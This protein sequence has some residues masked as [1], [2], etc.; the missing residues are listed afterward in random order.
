M[1]RNTRS[2]RARIFF[3][4]A[5]L[6]VLLSIF[7]LRLVEIQVVRADELNAAALDTRSSST[8]IIGARGDIV[9]AN[10]TVLAGSVQRFDIS[11][12]PKQAV[13]ASQAGLKESDADFAVKSRAV[14][15]ADTEKLGAALGKSGAEILGVIDAA[16]AENPKSDHAYIAKSV[17]TEVW[18]AV[19]DLDIPW[20]YAQSLP[21]RSYPNGAVAG[22][23]VGFVGA[24][25]E[26]QAGLELGQ[27]SCLAGIDGKEAYETGAD[28]VRLPDTTRTISEAKPGGTLQLTIDSDLQW[29]S[30]QALAEQAQATGA[31]WGSLVV[32][33]AKTGKLLTV[34]DYPSVDPNNVDGTAAE[35]RGSRAFAAS[36]EPGSTFKALTSA[37]VIDS[38]QADPYSQVVAPY[39]MIF[40]NGADVNDSSFHGDDHLTLTGVLIDSSNTGM[41]QF[42]ERISDD[43]RYEYMKKFGLGKE[44]EVHFPSEDSGDLNGDGPSTWDN[45]TRYATMFGQGMTSTAIQNASVYQAIA[46]NGVRLP[47][48]LTTGCTKADGTVVDQ[49][50]TEGVQVVSPGAARAT[51]D[52]LEMVYKKGWLASQ[53]NVPGYRVA[54]KTGTAQM[55][56]GTGKYSKDYIVSITGYA[57]ADDPQYVV[58]VSLARPVNMN[59]SAAPA[60]VFQ[61]VMSQV[62]KKYRVVPSGAPAPELPANW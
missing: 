46:N 17:D 24:D 26:A 56:D 34:A 51:S 16:L 45:Q 11:I 12:S 2:H 44:T 52:M 14:L 53:W 38:G 49:P 43:S 22:N 5:M 48:Q 59:T 40:P 18:R 32:M 60:P 47:V 9:D 57:P 62:L 31:A 7:V 15:V 28:N 61:E 33:E 3:A 36:Y 13:A 29:F 19:D 10:G 50:N 30:Q 54:A 21:A 20:Q 25:G 39:R 42:G 37:I 8:P 4:S 55:S 58:S 23:L 6:F 35:D 41:S 27:D 1:V